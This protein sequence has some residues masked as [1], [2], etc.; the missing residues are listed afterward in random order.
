MAKRLVRLCL[1]DADVPLSNDAVEGEVVGAKISLEGVGAGMPAIFASVFVGWKESSRVASEAVGSGT[2][3]VSDS[4]VDVAWR[5]STAVALDLTASEL[6][7]FV[8]M[9]AACVGSVGRTTL[10]DA[11]AYRFPTWPSGPV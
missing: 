10:L 5:V 7:V 8:E 1:K 9:A 3:N 11:G 2:S 4:V 6:V